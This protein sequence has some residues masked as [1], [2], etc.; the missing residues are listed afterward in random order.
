[1]PDVALDLFANQQV[2]GDDMAGFGKP[3]KTLSHALAD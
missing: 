1:L 3:G 2:C